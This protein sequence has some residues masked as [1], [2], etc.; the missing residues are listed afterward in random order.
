MV[1][2][3]VHP[4]G[5]VHQRWELSHERSWSRGSQSERLRSKGTASTG[6]RGKRGRSMSGKEALVTAAGARAEARGG[7]QSWAGTCPGLPRKMEAGLRFELGSPGLVFRVLSTM[8]CRPFR[9]LSLQVRYRWT[10][11]YWPL[12]TLCSH[13]GPGVGQACRSHGAPRSRVS[14]QHGEGKWTLSP[15]GTV[16]HTWSVSQESAVP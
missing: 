16:T 2:W 5:S 8:P 10:L 3:K 13:S 7:R 6:T 4:R 12:A 14:G 1:T 9:L 15:S 11:P